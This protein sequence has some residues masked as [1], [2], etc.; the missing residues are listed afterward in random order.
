MF[1]HRMRL[2]GDKCGGNTAATSWIS[3]WELVLAGAKAQFFRG[4]ACGE[5]FAD[6]EAGKDLAEQF[7]AAEFAGDFPELVLRKAQFFS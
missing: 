1:I 2:N 3:C 7:V 5:L 6:A 4:L